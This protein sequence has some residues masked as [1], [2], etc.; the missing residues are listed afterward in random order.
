MEH[1]AFLSTPAYE[2]ISKPSP[3]GGRMF[4]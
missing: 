2:F 1:H 3:D 4:A